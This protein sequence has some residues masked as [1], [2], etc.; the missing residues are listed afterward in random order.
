MFS[1]L[2]TRTKARICTAALSRPDLL[3]YSLTLPSTKVKKQFSPVA[4]AILRRCS[5]S[6]SIPAPAKTLR[7]PVHKV[8]PA[9]DSKVRDVCLDCGFVAYKNP[10]V[11]A[12]AVATTQDGRVLLCRRA[13]EPRR[14]TWTLPAGFMELGESVEDGALREAFEEADVKCTSSG[15]LALYSVPA[16]G[17][18]HVFVA[19]TIDEDYRAATPTVRDEGVNEG[20]AA[21]ISM[22]VPAA[23]STFYGC[24]PESLESR[25]FPLHEIPWADLA[26]PT[27]RQA[28]LH[29]VRRASAGSNVG[30]LIPDVATITERLPGPGEKMPF[31]VPDAE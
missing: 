24:G 14:G 7:G 20:A 4:S 30:P 19:A 10:L 21:S 12:G 9:G 31:P 6:S 22:S 28:L 26:F 17:Q 1:G 2:V 25:L 13:I 8:V 18:V 3:H 15:L 29:H 27:V 11:V 16:A 5:T 23:A